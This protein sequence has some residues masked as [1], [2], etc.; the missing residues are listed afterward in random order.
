MTKNTDSLIGENIRI[1]TNLTRYF[2]KNIYLPH[3]SR[4]ELSQ[5]QL[6]ILKIVGSY[7]SITGTEIARHLGVTRAAASQNIEYLANKDLILRQPGIGDRRRKMIILTSDGQ[8]VIEKFDQICQYKRQH[9]LEKFDSAEKLQF[10]ELLQKYIS[11]SLEVDENLKLICLQ[12][13]E[14]YG[15]GC[16]QKSHTKVCDFAVVDSSRKINGNGI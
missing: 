10:L 5:I 4:H 3:A 2:V 16:P 11:S 6:M 15:K 8:T 9:V 13:G 7:G 1:L 14:E 12:C